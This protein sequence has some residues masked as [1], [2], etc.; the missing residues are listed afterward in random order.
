MGTAEVVGWWKAK[1]MEAVYKLTPFTYARG[2]EVN[3][4]LEAH[5]S[6]TVAFGSNACMA[7]GAVSPRDRSNHALRKGL[8][9]H[10]VY[11]LT[12]IAISTNFKVH[13]PLLESAVH[14]QLFVLRAT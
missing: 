8:T 2:I 14:R 9:V 6:R 4:N 12:I 5:Q 7:P 10:E 13:T 11:I 1:G 3:L